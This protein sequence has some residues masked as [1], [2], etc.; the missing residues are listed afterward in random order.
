MG[1][2]RVSATVFLALAV[3][4]GAAAAGPAGAATGG[5]IAPVHTGGV[6]PGQ[7]PPPPAPTGSLASLA[8]SLA[9]APAGAPTAVRRAIAAGN[10]L[11]HKPYRY[12]GG[13]ASF[14]DTGYDC[15]GTVSFALHGARLLRAPLDST[16][17]ETW[18]KPGPGRWITVYANAGHAYMTVAGLRLDTS[19]TNGRGPRWQLTPRSGDGFVARHPAGL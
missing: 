4:A 9:T 3:A 18:G 5:A 6:V 14:K 10:K 1:Q 11:Q 2:G 17:F 7:L 12:G 15:S 8:G 13:H 16:G 19:G